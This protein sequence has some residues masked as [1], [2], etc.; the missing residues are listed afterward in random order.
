MESF[1]TKS[2]F[3]QQQQVAEPP[4]FEPSSASGA[5][6]RKKLD[7]N[8]VEK[9][10][11]VKSIKS[12]GLVGANGIMSHYNQ[13]SKKSFNNNSLTKIPSNTKRNARERKRVRTIN[14]YF[15]QLQKY[16]PYTKPAPTAGSTPGPKKLSKVETLKAAIE[17]IEYLQQYAPASTKNSAN[18]SSSSS[19]S[20]KLNCV[21]S[22]S[23]SVS[24]T[25]SLQSSPT[26]TTST[27]FT[28]N[29]SLVEKLKIK[30]ESTPTMK[31]EIASTNHKYKP[32]SSDF[33]VTHMT[34][35]Q[36]ALATYDGSYNHNGQAYNTATNPVAPVQSNNHSY[37]SESEV[38]YN[39]YTASSYQYHD[40]HQ[41]SPINAYS[42]YGGHVAANSSAKAAHPELT[43]SPTYS[44]SSSECY[45]TYNNQN[46]M[47]VGE[48]NTCPVDYNNNTGS[49]CFNGRFNGPGSFQ[50][51]QY[52]HV[53]NGNAPTV[54]YC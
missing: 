20:S 39:N 27:S 43:S 6:C 32:T 45:S 16:L 52:N 33:H 40:G 7:F 37:P 50:Y 48:G 22:P 23:S 15:N 8:A 42:Q 21:S 41:V 4:L 10:H 30:C 36:L 29:M 2:E 49:D 1:V 47:A 25:Q 12:M 19:S 14:D 9:Q 11:K 5:N 18:P 34:N 17:F 51:Q 3:I 28:S 31:Q 54:Q 38:Y 35:G 53:T 24:S 26:S 46:L 44:T 13:V